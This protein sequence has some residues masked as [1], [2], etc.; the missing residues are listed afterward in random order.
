VKPE[1][2]TIRRAGKVLAVAVS[3]IAV[4]G[5]TQ[6][7]SFPGLLGYLLPSRLVLGVCALALLGAL[8]RG[9]RWDL[10]TVLRGMAVAGVLVGIGLFLFILI[11]ADPEGPD[12]APLSRHALAAL[13]QP[14]TWLILFGAAFATAMPV[15]AG[16]AAVSVL[17]P[18]K[19]TR[20]TKDNRDNKDRDCS[21]PSI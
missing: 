11:A 7:L 5:L 18:V 13:G 2:Y 8:F 4:L 6:S 1:S 17:R 3:S 10:A 21:H 9:L 16:F 12:R 20:D 15:L 19:D 14:I